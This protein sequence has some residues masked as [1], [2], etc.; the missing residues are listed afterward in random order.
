VD[1][2]TGF[3]IA[4]A[5]RSGSCPPGYQARPGRLASLENCRPF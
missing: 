1:P 2:L 4:A 5:N 3:T